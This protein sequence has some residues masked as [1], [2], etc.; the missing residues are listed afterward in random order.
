MTYSIS[1]N[2]WKLSI[3][4]EKCCYPVTFL[5]GNYKENFRKFHIPY[6]LSYSPLAFPH[7]PQVRHLKRKSDY[8]ISLLKSPSKTQLCLQDLSMNQRPAD[9]PTTDYTTHHLPAALQCLSSPLHTPCLGFF[10]LAFSLAFPPPRIFSH[11]APL[12]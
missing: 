2:L 10:F 6:L 3:L 5:Q 7:S 4:Q 9:L 11:P 12:S 8:T 1:P